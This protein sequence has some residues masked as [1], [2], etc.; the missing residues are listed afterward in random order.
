M[1]NYSPEPIRQARLTWQV[2]RNGQSTGIQG[3]T[4]VDV[5]QGE[6]ALAAQL[7][8][9]LPDVEQPTGLTF[10]T[11]LEIGRR[12]YVNQWHTRLY[13][14]RL[15]PAALP[16]PLFADPFGLRCCQAFGARPIPEEKPLSDR[17]VYVVGSLDR[18]VTAAVQRG[19][20]MILLDQGGESCPGA[21]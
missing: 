9:D 20:C 17:A 8:L 4:D 11:D 10:A 14:A 5:G 13:P 3:Q 19:A 1:S 16:V 21:A 12:H 15:K 2:R 18:R 7:A 6:V